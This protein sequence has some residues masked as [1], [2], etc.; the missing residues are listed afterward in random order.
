M[1]ESLP[2]EHPADS[3]LTLYEGMQRAGMGF[4]EV[5]MRQL[6]VG[7][8]AASI[9]VEAYILGLLR[10]DAYQHNVIAQAINEYFIARG[11]NHP[12]S[13]AELPLD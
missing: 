6:S 3:G 4:D 11:E 8:D 7:G 5:W 12:V 9:E 10:A 2:D 1:T 13:Y